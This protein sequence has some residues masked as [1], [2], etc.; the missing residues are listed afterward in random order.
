MVYLKVEFKDKDCFTVIYYDEVSLS[1]EETILLFIKM[2]SHHLE[3]VYHYIFSGSYRLLIYW[4]TRVVIMEFSQ[5]SPLGK[6]DF[7]VDL[8]LN[9]TVLFE[10]EDFYY[11][12]GK[13]WFYQGKYYVDYD[14]LNDKFDLFEYGRLVYGEEAKKV[15]NNGRLFLPLL[16]S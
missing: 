2:I 10:F 16:K 15:M 7:D 3:K 13:K 14:R 1:D 12:E 8:L 6:V 5:I 11:L 9:S 4:K